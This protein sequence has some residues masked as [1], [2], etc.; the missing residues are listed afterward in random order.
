MLVVTVYLALVVPS[1]Y[2]I[3]RPWHFPLTEGWAWMKKGY[4]GAGYTL[5]EGASCEEMSSHE[6][7]LEEESEE[8]VW[9]ERE[10]VLSLPA[11]SEFKYPLIMKRL[12]KTYKGRGGAGPKLAVNDVTFAVEEGIIF[13]LLGPNGGKVPCITLMSR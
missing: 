10:R 4:K 9:Q 13:G 1:E 7:G 6:I 8:D 5:T 12:C 11:G 2:G 3:A